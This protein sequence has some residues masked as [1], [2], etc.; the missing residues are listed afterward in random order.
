[1][2]VKTQLD[3]R[4]KLYLEIN[5]A[6]MLRGIPGVGKT[7]LLEYLAKENGWE[8]VFYQC[9]PGS[10]EEDM[11]YKIIPDENTPSGV[12]VVEGVLPKALR[13][14]KEGKKVLLIL[15]EI[16]KTRPIFDAFL[17]DFLQNFRVSVPGF[18]IQLNEEE[19]GNIFVGLTSNDMRDFSEALLRRVAVVEIPPL[20]E[21]P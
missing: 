2:R 4:V 5:K 17:L 15:D 7:S 6:V 12:K 9:T 16:D 18:E 3:D 8:T 10:T 21:T 11:L 19:K 20:Q 13:L 1:M 14:A